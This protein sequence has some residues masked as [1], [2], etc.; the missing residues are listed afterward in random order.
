MKLCDG[1]DGFTEMIFVKLQLDFEST[2]REYS[3]I[4]DIENSGASSVPHP[5]EVN[6]KIRLVPEVTLSLR[7]WGKFYKGE[8]FVKVF[9]RDGTEVPKEAIFSR[10]FYE[11]VALLIANAKRLSWGEKTPKREICI[12][13]DYVAYVS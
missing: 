10:Q 2:V 6:G 8:S 9:F 13:D 1:F 11:H 5:I 12:G 7:E 4:Y 3:R